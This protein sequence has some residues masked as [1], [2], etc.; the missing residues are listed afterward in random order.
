M[1][2]NNR[3]F[4][5][6]AASRTEQSYIIM[7]AHINGYNRL[8]GGQL[9]QWIDIVAGIVARRHC[10]T[11]ITTV[12]IDNLLFKA[13]AHVNDLIV[14]QGQVTYVGRTS[15]EV[16]VLTFV[17]DI[18][19]MRKLINRAYLVMVAIDEQERPTPVPAIK[20]ETME[21]QFEYECAIKRDAIRKQRRTEAF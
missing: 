14:L 16:R 20:P 2:D 17:E 4:K 8:F 5:T 18:H 15:M 13:P 6:V 9:M 21:E 12:S 19:G 10:E 1:T 7:P 11:N 3:P